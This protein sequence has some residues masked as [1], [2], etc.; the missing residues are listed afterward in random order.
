MIK[1]VMRTPFDGI[2]KPEAL[3]D[4]L[5]GYWSRGITLE[6][7]LVYSCLIFASNVHSCRSNLKLKS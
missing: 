2:E 1:K 7:R 5:Q 3:K 4:D 6:H